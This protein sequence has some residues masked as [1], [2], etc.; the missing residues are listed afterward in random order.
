MTP[1]E[2]ARITHAIEQWFISKD[3]Q[4]QKSQGKGNPQAGSR[5]RVTGGGHLNG[6]NQLVVDEIERAGAVGLELRVNRR[7][8]LPGW[9]RGSKAWDLLVLQHGSPILAVE[10]KSM[11]GSEGKNLNNRTDEALGIAEDAREAE[12]RGG[13]P[14]HLR[15]AYIF[16]MEATPEATKPRLG[17]R[18]DF[19]FHGKS[20][21]ERLAVTAKRM[22]DAELYH[23]VWVIGATQ[24][25]L[26]F[27][28]PD[29]EVGWDRFSADLRSGFKHGKATEAP[30]P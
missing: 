16:L 6:I 12:R 1:E 4:G 15:R 26:G 14:R 20:Y 18:P 29:P 21:L 5:S 23:L 27:S 13:L 3:A 10:Y 11:A 19:G 7:A 24:N 17:I 28:E 30:H 8:V 22:R 2:K 25:P 9:Y